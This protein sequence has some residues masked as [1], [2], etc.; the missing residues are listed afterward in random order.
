MQL[1]ASLLTFHTYL[2]TISLCFIFVFSPTLLPALTPR[3]LYTRPLGISGAVFITC[4]ILCVHVL[5]IIICSVN[6]QSLRL[7]KRYNYVIYDQFLLH[8]CR[9]AIFSHSPEEVSC[10]LW[11]A[12]RN[13]TPLDIPTLLNTFLRGW[14]FMLVQ[15]YHIC[16]Y[17][18]NI[19]K[20]RMPRV[21]CD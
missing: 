11:N 17:D 5:S 12:L 7:L 18:V 21:P 14:Q 2:V 4:R 9:L 15:H 10:V 3:C 20:H 13:S 6:C 16:M 8:N 19:Y 1:F